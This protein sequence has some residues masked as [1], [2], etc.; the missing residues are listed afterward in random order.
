MASLRQPTRFPPDVGA[1]E[2]DG[3]LGIGLNRLL[4]ALLDR[5]SIRDTSFVFRGPGRLLP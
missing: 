5:S 3:G 2:T 4:T 1:A